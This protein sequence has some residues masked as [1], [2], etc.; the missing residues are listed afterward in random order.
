MRNQKR[1]HF[2]RSPTP[3]RKSFIVLCQPHFLGLDFK[4]ESDDGGLQQEDTTTT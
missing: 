4:F 1:L 3:S 2:A